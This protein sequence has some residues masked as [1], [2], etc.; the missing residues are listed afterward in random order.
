[1]KILIAYSVGA[2]SCMFTVCCN[3][4]R[5]FPYN[6]QALNFT[7][8]Y[9]AIFLLVTPTDKHNDISKRTIENVKR[10]KAA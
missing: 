3:I 10:L 5:H 7:T 1:M 8:H 2:A 6:Y 9:L 4:S